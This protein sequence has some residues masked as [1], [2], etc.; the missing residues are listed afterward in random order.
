[1]RIGLDIDGVLADF[2]TS[3]IRLIREV[4]GVQLPSPSDD[5]PD[6]WNYT[7]NVLSRE[8][9]DKVWKKIKTTKFWV[10]LDPLPDCGTVLRQLHGGEHEVY[11]ITTRPGTRAKW[12]TEGW[13][14]EQGCALPTV[15]IADTSDSKGRLARGLGLDVF[16]DDRPSNCIEVHLAMPDHCDVY[17]VDRPYNQLPFE[18]G[19]YFDCAGIRRVKSALEALERYESFRRAA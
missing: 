11:F 9:E 5:Y 7:K 18:G 17:L 14:F 12:W 15:L 13:L 4:T 10:T 2:N 3:F 16:I 19:M 6:R 8:Q 1:M